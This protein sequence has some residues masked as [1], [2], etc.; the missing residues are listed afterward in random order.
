MMTQ[1]V[2]EQLE[3]HL[4]AFSSNVIWGV[5]IVITKSILS[6]WMTPM[7]YTITRLGF[8]MVVLWIISFSG[9]KEKVGLRDLPLIFLAGM[10]GIAITQTLYTVGIKLTTPVLWS[11]VQTSNNFV[12][13]ILA[14]L[15]LKEKITPLKTIGVI[16]G[17]A[18]TAFF[19]LKN[20][21]FG[22]SSGNALGIA[23]AFICVLCHG[24]YVLVIKKTSQKFAS[25]T[26]TKWMFFFSW[27]VL[28]P[29]G[30]RELP[31]QR[32]YSPDRTL[33]SVLQLGVALSFFIIAF[34]LGPV[35]IKRLKPTT[36]NMYS[37]IQPL[38]AAVASIVV[39]Q[40]VFTWDKP[41]AMLI[42]VVS[43]YLV[44]KDSMKE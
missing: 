32:I 31:A 27:I 9:A 18:G 11:L 26:L 17:I 30:I 8:A 36:Q 10:L 13:L 23:V 34:F 19:I 2:K 22:G 4:A 39:G 3:G 20:G 24:V 41:V 6:S 15:F 28:L 21:N 37:N 35:S 16:L 12:V 42:I 44:T 5:N 29:F 14:A 43:L 38:S 1:S 25:L 40:D 7:G 33:F